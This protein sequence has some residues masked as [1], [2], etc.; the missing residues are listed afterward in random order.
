[1]LQRGAWGSLQARYLRQA[2]Q[3]WG[4]VCV[5][6]SMLAADAREASRPSHHTGQ[7]HNT[8]QGQASSRN[9][10]APPSPPPP[11]TCVQVVHRELEQLCKAARLVG[12][13]QPDCQ[14]PHPSGA[15][16]HT[17]I[18]TE[19]RASRVRDSQC[20]LQVWGGPIG[21]SLAKGSMP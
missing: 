3:L 9:K 1:M 4:C 8:P 11:L 21:H 7:G 10:R 15:Q 6:A 13:P 5:R 17:R 20:F 16:L 2:I 12:L 18:E 14:Q 19:T